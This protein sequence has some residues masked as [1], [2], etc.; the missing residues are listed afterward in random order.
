MS[1]RPFIPV[2]SRLSFIWAERGHVEV[3][4]FA[5]VLV[6][7]QGVVDL[8]IGVASALLL[9]PGT[10]I[11]HGAVKACADAECLLLWVGEA[12]VRCYA[13]GDPGRNADALL[14]QAAVVLEPARRLAAARRIFRRMF[15]E[16]AP[17]GRSIEQLRGLEGAKVWDLYAS[18]ARSTGIDW[19]GRNAKDAHDAVNQAIS[20]ANAA[21]YG[22]VEAVILAL[23]YAPS[24]GVVHNGA[25]RSFVY[26]IADCLKFSTATPLAMRVAKD[27]PEDIEG[28]TRR[29]CRDLFRA[30]SM[31]EQIG[32]TVIEVLGG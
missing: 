25:A 17:A 26:D 20:V 5:V 19:V 2:T 3:E 23:G 13:A 27:G 10:R 21:L 28:R 4:G 14:H 16:E 12:G 22:L 32:R 18:I 31:A 24:V 6:T 15:N 7:E 1:L 9:E 30:E 8:P 29:A 11:T